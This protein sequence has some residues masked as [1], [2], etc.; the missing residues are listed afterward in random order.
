MK[1]LC[2][3]RFALFTGL[4]LYVQQYIWSFYSVFN[5]YM[6]LFLENFYLNVGA[7]TVLKQNYI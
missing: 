4:L 7:S 1:Q 6:V 2:L 5:Q 3:K